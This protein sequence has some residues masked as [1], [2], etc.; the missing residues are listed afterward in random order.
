MDISGVLLCTRPEQ[1][2]AVRQ[3]LGQMPQVEVHEALP[4]GRMVLVLDTASP[5]EAHALCTA[6]RRIPGV[7]SVSLAFHYFDGEQDG[8]L[9][10]ELVEAFCREERG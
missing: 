1:A 8:V 2:G 7:L 9:D 6:I 3:R 5:D 4:D 10:P